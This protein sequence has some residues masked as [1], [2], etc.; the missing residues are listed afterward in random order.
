[1]PAANPR[2][3]GLR[4]GTELRTVARELR[5]MDD[6]EITGRFRRDLRAAAA[7]L[8][9]AVRSSVMSTPS[10]GPPPRGRPGLR[11]SIAK[12]VKLRVRSGGRLA[13]VAIL[14]DGRKMP[15]REGALPAYM[16]GTKP[17]WR[18]PVYQSEHNPDPPWVQQPPK[19]YFYRVV[20]PLGFKS[21]IAIGKVLDGIT[22]DITGRH[23]P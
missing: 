15:P 23:I 12:A 3:W 14:V 1:M 4:H 7:P 2:G 18:H 20:R 6:R 5:R 16:E 22:R 17:R 9:P 10:K 13:S 11:R 21:R 19:P 8:V